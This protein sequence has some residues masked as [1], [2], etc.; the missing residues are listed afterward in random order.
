M[1]KVN[2]TMLPQSWGSINLLSLAIQNMPLKKVCFV[3]RFI[4][5]SKAAIMMDLKGKF[6]DRNTLYTI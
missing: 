2:K 6:F 5:F 4:K 3:S 1:F